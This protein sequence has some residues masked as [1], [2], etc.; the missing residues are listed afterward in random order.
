[1]RRESEKMRASQSGRVRASDTHK[2]RQSS[3][4]QSR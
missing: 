1:M 3:H 4:R 2:H